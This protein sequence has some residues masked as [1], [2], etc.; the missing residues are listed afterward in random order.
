[1]IVLTEREE[2]YLE[3]IDKL[4]A[5]LAKYKPKWQ[6][7]AVPE[8]G[9]YWIHSNI[10]NPKANVFITTLNKGRELMAK[11][12]WAGPLIEPSEGGGDA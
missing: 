11:M 8:T 10:G 9:R 1:M 6:S 3:E 4:R 7:G 5:E 2:R 12:R